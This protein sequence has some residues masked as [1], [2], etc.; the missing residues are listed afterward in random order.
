MRKWFYQNEF[1]FV[2]ELIFE[3]FITPAYLT[4]TSHIQNFQ[5]S[6]NQFLS[7]L[8]IR[9]YRQRFATELALLFLALFK[10]MGSMIDNMLIFFII[11]SKSKYWNKKTI[12]TSTYHRNY[13][14]KVIEV[15]FLTVHVIGWTSLIAL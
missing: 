7:C 15:K 5:I 6:V 13:S 3:C 8:L 1:L 9:W 2:F 4:G 14:L 10:S 11:R 12:S